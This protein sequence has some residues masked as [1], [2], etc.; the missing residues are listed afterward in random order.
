MCCDLRIPAKSIGYISDLNSNSAPEIIEDRLTQLAKYV[1]DL[2]EKY[3]T[4]VEI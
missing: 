4:S 1:P 2:V 3:R